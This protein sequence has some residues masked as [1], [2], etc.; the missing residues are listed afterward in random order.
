MTRSSGDL[1][2][3]LETKRAHF[4]WKRILISPVILSIRI[5][6]SAQGSLEAFAA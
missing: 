4:L 5:V 6:L 2:R 3:A 1:K